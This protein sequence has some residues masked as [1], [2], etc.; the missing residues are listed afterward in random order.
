M[1]IADMLEIVLFSDPV[2]RYA[3]NAL[4]IYIWPNINRGARV[5]IQVIKGWAYVNI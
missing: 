1:T 5:K 3:S 4:C 2:N